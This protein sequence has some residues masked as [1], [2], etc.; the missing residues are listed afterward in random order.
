MLNILE[1]TLFL[2]LNEKYGKRE[3]DDIIK[4]ILKIEKSLI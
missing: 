1:I 3:A 2:Y 4:S